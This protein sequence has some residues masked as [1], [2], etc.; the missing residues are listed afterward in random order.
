MKLVIFTPASIKSAIARMASLVSRDLVSQGHTVTIVRTEV[1]PFIATNS[2]DFGA[3]VLVWD[4]QSEVRLAIQNA[5]ACVYQ[6][7]D[8]FSYHAGC[9]RWLQEVPGLVCLHDFFLGNLFHGWAQG[10]RVRADAIINQWYGPRLTARF[11]SF[12]GA[13]SLIEGTR[14]VMPM[15]EWVCSMA[16]GVITHSHWGCE[17][18]INSC[19]GPVRV[20]PLAYSANT[21]LVHETLQVSAEKANLKLLTIGHVNANKRVTS[22]L[23]AI[24][25]SPILRQHVTYRLVGLI[26]P[27]VRSE[28]MDFAASRGVTLS[29][30]GEVN[31]QELASAIAESDIISCLRW[32]TLEAAS[33]SAI[34]AML[35]GKA[36][37]V[38]NTGFYAEIPDECVVKIDQSNEIAELRLALESLLND[39][40]QI[41]KLGAV[42]QTWAKQAFTSKN[43]AEQL[44]ETLKDVLRSL[45]ARNSVNFF[46]QTLNRWCPDRDFYESPYVLDQLRIFDKIN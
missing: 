29:I 9:I 25:Q 10:D 22:M 7:G 45:P 17:R 44:V 2:H 41:V 21:L 16:A 46:C 12:S 37:I 11:F 42:A 6:I 32:P 33:A 20:V 14:D 34:E 3:K 15:T 43:Y 1:R 40:S 4:N 19:P 18:V 5:D 8:N 26:Q 38:T 36:V 13:E 39:R 35:S 28:L 27:E 24:G 23:E 30:A 31:D